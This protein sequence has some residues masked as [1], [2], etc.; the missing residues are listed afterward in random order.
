[1]NSAVFCISGLLRDGTKGNLE[2]KARLLAVTSCALSTAETGSAAVAAG[3][4]L[5]EEFDAVGICL[6]SPSLLCRA[7]CGLVQLTQLSDI[8]VVVSMLSKEHGS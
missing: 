5:A 2:D 8:C 4:A 3:K 6:L 1:M 7:V